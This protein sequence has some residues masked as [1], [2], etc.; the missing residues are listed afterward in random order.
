MMSA[1][2]GS[3]TMV[4]KLPFTSAASTNGL[5]RYS[6]FGMDVGDGSGRCSWDVADV[7]V[8][9]RLGGRGARD[10]DRLYRGTNN[11]LLVSAS[12]PE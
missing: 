1:Y 4:L 10:I 6:G 11:E 5:H 7:G 12:Y 3:M 2:L 8:V 9:E